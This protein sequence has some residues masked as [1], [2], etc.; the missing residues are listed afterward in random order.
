MLLMLLCVCWQAEQE[1]IMNVCSSRLHDCG[2][3]P[4]W[5]ASRA[6]TTSLY[7]QAIRIC[8]CKEGDGAVGL[9]EQVGEPQPNR[10][11]GFSGRHARA[12]CRSALTELSL[13]SAYRSAEE[14]PAIPPEWF[15]LG[16]MTELQVSV[17]GTRSCT[18]RSP[19]GSSS[20]NTVYAR[21]R[22][23]HALR[24]CCR[25][26]PAPTSAAACQSPRLWASLS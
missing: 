18:A 2:A 13:D 25:T 15:G 3:A 23:H 11:P 7:G 10:Q 17:E 22:T 21:C 1:R 14:S 20:C 24:V 12:L 8:V 9:L 19:L 5:A 16:G 26:S 4:R 6:A